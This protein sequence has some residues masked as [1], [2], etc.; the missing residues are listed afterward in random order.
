MF[1]HDRMKQVHTRTR[2]PGLREAYCGLKRGR[3]L[4]RPEEAWGDEL[5]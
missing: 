1:G 4:V 2:T 5:R 3:W